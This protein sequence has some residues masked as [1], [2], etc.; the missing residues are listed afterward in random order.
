MKAHPFFVALALLSTLASAAFADGLII[1]HNPPPHHRPPP[2]WPQPPDV[3]LR[4]HPIFAPLEVVYHNV[5]V[6]ID[7]QKATTRVD[8][9]FSNPNDAT[10][11]GEYLFP[12]PKGAHI[13]KFTMRV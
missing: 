3:W 1:I 7:G 8:Q 13:D 4:P 11:E 2:R 9:E 12:I 6:T 5:D 10:L